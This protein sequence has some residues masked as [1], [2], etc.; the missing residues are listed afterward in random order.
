MQYMGG[1]ARI[2]KDIVSVIAEH[3]Q[4]RTLCVEPFMGGCNVTAHLA[5]VFDS[6][7]AY[8]SRLDMVLMRQALAN[9]WTPP[10]HVSEDE[11]KRL[12]HAEPSA[13]RGFA[14]QACA[15]GGNWFRGYARN[16]IGFDYVGASLRTCA[17]ETKLMRNVHFE[18]ADFM[19]EVPLRND[20]VL[21]CDPPYASTT[22]YGQGGFDHDRFWRRVRQWVAAGAIAFVSEQ[23]A[24]SDFVSVWSKLK[25]KGLRSANGQHDALAECL[26]MHESQAPDKEKPRH[27]AGAKWAARSLGGRAP[28]ADQE[29]VKTGAEET[30]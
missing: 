30:A 23:V 13:L 3:K 17:K 20:A 1:K 25:T 27:E 24:P 4:D 21:Y 7:L 8:D 12:R 5:Q 15:F 18:H 16:A 22:G 29:W 28:A 10:S 2:A 6:V 26:F 11:Y 9:G 14:G 19:Y